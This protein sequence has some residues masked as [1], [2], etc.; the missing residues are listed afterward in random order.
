[1]LIANLMVSALLFS[2]G[3]KVEARQENNYTACK[4]YVELIDPRVIASRENFNRHITKRNVFHLKKKDKTYL[5]ELLQVDIQRLGRH[6][7]FAGQK[8]HNL[9]HLNK[10]ISYEHLNKGVSHIMPEMASK[11]FNCDKATDDDLLSLDAMAILYSEGAEKIE[12]FSLDSILSFLIVRSYPQEE[13]SLEL[14]VIDGGFFET[15]RITGGSNDL[16]DEITDNYRE[17]GGRN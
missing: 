2:I 13:K 8:H 15:Y 1:M 6:R 3:E 7:L 11:K 14:I 9:K 4:A 10:Y 5:P 17:I 16:L 12:I